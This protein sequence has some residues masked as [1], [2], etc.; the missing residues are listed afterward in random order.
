MK[1]FKY[2]FS[3]VLLFSTLT[4][5]GQSTETRAVDNFKSIS[6]QSGIDLHLTQ[7]SNP[8]VEIKAKSDMMDK[9]I[10]KVEGGRLKI[11]ID[12]QNWKWNKWNSTGPM[13]AY[14][15]VAN[16]ESLTASGGS[17]VESRGTWKSDDFEIEASGGSD[18]EM[19][20]DVD[21]L[22]VTCSGGS[23]IDLDGSVDKLELTSSGGSDFNGRKLI[24][25]D[26]NIRS[27]GGS[28]VY[29]HVSDKL[30]ARASGASDIHYSGN[31]QIRD[32]DTS[33]SSDVK[34]Y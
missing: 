17:D 26:V 21:I 31:P 13:D 4:L 16:L 11:Y 2:S 7:S 30:V 32:I 34:K 27:S 8:S 1:L 29:I 15:S 18:I 33:S 23:D 12:K 28:D 24:A 25:K 22:E 10:T 20:L 9:I 6:I 14:V 3:L 5:V 19:T